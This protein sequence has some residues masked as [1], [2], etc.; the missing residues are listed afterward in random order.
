MEDYGCKLK[1]PQ[2]QFSDTM[3]KKI[4][5]AGGRFERGRLVFDINFFNNEK[6][7]DIF[8]NEEP[9]DSSSS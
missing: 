9:G 1:V 2:G 3:I 7:H 6:I 5:K 4:K 8:G